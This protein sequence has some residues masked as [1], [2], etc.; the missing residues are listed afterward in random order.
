MC[1][2]LD[3]AEDPLYISEANGDDESGD[4]SELKPVK[5]LLQVCVVA[6][7]NKL[8]VQ[9]VGIGQTPDQSILYVGN[10][11][12]CRRTLPSILR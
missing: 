4:G 5:S 7:C 2:C 12:S 10:E 11:D 6:P 9:L 3:L 1:T 8:K